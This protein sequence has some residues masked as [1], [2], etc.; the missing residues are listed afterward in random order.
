MSGFSEL[1]NTYSS[2]LLNID[3][4]DSLFG[5]QSENQHLLTPDTSYSQQSSSLTSDPDYL[6]APAPLSSCPPPEAPPSLQRI[7]PDRKTIFILYSDMTKSE[8]VTW[9]LKTDFGRKKTLRWDTKHQADIWNQFHQVANSATG[10]PKVLCK[11]CM[12]DLDHPMTNRNGSSSM[13]KHIQ[14][15]KCRNSSHQAGRQT[16]IAQFMDSTVST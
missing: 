15:P 2:S 3:V 8:F 7:K 6:H 1:R 9:W 5:L 16:N 13:G 10:E 4:T 14:G 11:K 12:K